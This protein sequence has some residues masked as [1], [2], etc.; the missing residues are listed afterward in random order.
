MLK[1]QSGENSD[2][3]TLKNCGTADIETVCGEDFKRGMPA[4]RV[5][6]WVAEHK[7]ICARK[8]SQPLSFPTSDLRFAKKG[9]Q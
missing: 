1:T 4:E 3:R 8:D 9:D 5:V 2:W 6:V 7:K